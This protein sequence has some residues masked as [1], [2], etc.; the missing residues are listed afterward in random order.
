MNLPS[1]WLVP[2]RISKNS[3]GDYIINE[4]IKAT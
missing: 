3:W 1:G 2:E 4:A